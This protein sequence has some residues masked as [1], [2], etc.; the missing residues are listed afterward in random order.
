[1]A[2]KDLENDDN[3]AHLTNNT[4]HSLAWAGITVDLG[5]KISS[6]LRPQQIISNVDGLASAGGF[7]WPF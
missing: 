3:E 7:F 5:R 1:M 2:E 6:D 4:V